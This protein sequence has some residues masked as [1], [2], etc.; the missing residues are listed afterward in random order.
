MQLAGYLRNGALQEWN[1]LNQEDCNTLKAAVKTLHAKLD[2]GDQ[3]LSAL[4]SERGQ[5]YYS[6]L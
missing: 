6:F 1:L 3:T 5:I 2:T 4:L